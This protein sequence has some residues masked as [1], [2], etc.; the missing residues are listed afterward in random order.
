ML[1]QNGGFL[2]RCIVKLNLVLTSFFLLKKTYIIQ[3]IAKNSRFF[4]EIASSSPIAAGGRFLRSLKFSLVFACVRKLKYNSL[5]FIGEIRFGG[6]C[7]LSADGEEQ[8]QAARNRRRIKTKGNFL[9][10]II[11]KHSQRI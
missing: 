1:Q 3:K 7:W 6:S 10:T 8:Q 2:N 4:I 11:S 9:Y 5:F